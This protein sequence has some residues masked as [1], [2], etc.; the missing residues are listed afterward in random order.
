MKTIEDVEKL[1]KIIGQLQG[2]YSE[3]SILAKKS[4]NDGLNPFKLKLIN[5][6][7]EAAN[8]VLGDDY[9]P[10]E[11]FDNF[12]SDDMPSNSDVTIVLSQYMEEAERYR[13]D[14]VVRDGPFWHYKV[15]GRQSSIRSGAPS[16]VG[17]K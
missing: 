16:K 15:D 2:A 8:N 3:I 17:K 11:G 1:E 12:D 6:I 4:S 10:F 5:T 14:N 9:K 7:I 13:S